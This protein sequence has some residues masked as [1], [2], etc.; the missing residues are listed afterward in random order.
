MRSIERRI[1]KLEQMTEG[2]HNVN[3][4]FIDASTK[5]E[6]EAEAQYAAY[7]QVNGKPTHVMRFVGA[8][9]AR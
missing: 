8:T 4:C 1:G 2:I 5:A 9:L 6:A 3:V 7:K